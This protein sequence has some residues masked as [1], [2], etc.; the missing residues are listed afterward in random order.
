[1]DKIFLRKQ[2]FKCLSYLAEQFSNDKDKYFL[3]G[4]DY[5]WLGSSMAVSDPFT[6]RVAVINWFFRISYR[7]I[8]YDFIIE[9]VRP[10]MDQQNRFQTKPREKQRVQNERRLLLEQS[11]SAR[12]DRF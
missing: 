2:R 3:E 7:K 12:N 4:K 8:D 6:G 10:P 9:G 1:M 11:P 5:G